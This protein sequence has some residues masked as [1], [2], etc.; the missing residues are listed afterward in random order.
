MMSQKQFASLTLADLLEQKWLPGD[1]AAI[2]IKGLCLDHRR[3]RSGDV[4]VAMPGTRVDGRQFIND[5]I[6]AGA[7]A[8]LAQAQS[9][10]Q[11]I[12]W[13][14][15]APIIPLMGVNKLLSHVA[16]NFYGH[17]S[18]QMNLVGVTGT[19]GK[20]TCTQLLA[21]LLNRLNTSS[22]VM[23]TLGYGM[24]NSAHKLENLQDTGLT[25]TDAIATQK[26]L[27][28]LAA[29]GAKS[30]CMEV[31]S[32]SLAQ[33]RVEDLQ[34]SLALLTNLSRDH[35]D[36]HGDMQSYARAKQKL[37][38]RPEL[39]HR[40][41][42]WDDELG[43]Y[44]SGKSHQSAQTWTYSV[45]DPAAHIYAKSIKH[46]ALGI[47][48]ELESV[49]GK[50]KLATQLI[51]GFNLSNMLGVIVAACALGYPLVEVLE[52]CRYLV[53]VAGRME[54][55]GDSEDVSVV[56]DYAHTPDGLENALA[57]MRAHTKGKLTCLFGCGG[58]RDKGKRPMMAAI[59][60]KYADTVVVTSDNP[61]SEIPA[62][63][64]ADIHGGF[65]DLSKVVEIE[66]RADAI[67]Y[68]IVN[69]KSGDSVL[70]A[71]KGHEEYQQIGQDRLPFSDVKQ[72]RLA[73]RVRKS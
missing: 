71:G 4:F 57:A 55:V 62:A 25:T 70:I 43:R 12:E 29:Q 35:L 33:Y 69:A 42:N 19:N 68:C 31:S 61:R 50:G 13:L 47:E 27:A 7:V 38:E 11:T 53:S 64:I 65:N 9:E 26:I 15:Q 32:H 17:A 5:A 20:S 34:F 41:L 30:V 48:A 3:V 67:N 60:E 54:R 16:G 24:V 10:E 51:G 44:L 56:V 1:V 73:L 6:K 45:D 18:R 8:V 39:Q 36:Y 59:A 63:I 46:S 21:Q 23:G 37:F 66:D 58:D 40:V 22:A 72:A 14:G 28:E 2:D 49:W 52:Q